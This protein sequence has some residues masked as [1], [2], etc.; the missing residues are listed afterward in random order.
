M[1]G[2]TP[3]PWYGNQ[4]YVLKLAKDGNEFKSFLKSKKDKIRGEDYLFY[5]GVT[6]SLISSKGFA[7]RLSPGGFIFDVAGMTC[8][9]PEDSISLVL[10]VLNSRIAKFILLALNPTINFQV[11]DIERLPVPEERSPIIDSLVEECVELTRQGSRE[12]EITYEFIAPPES[13]GEVDDRTRLLSEKETLI[14][15]EVSKL[16]GLTDEDLFAIEREL[17]GNEISSGEEDIEEKEQ[18]EQEE[19]QAG[20][21]FS[22]E[23]WGRRW[24]S[25][26]VGIA[27]GRF[28]AGHEGGLGSG[29]FDSSVAESLT[30]MASPE[31]I[32]VNDEG[33]PNDLAERV[34]HILTTALGNSEAVSRTRMALGEGDSL[35]LLRNWFER[36]SGT[37]ENSFWKYHLKVYRKRP[38]YWPLQS[39]GRKFTLW[40]FHERLTKD[41]LYS[42][43]NSIVE[44]RMRLAERR[45]ADLRPRAE[46][47]RSA[48]MEMERARDL[49]EDLRTFSAN[50]LA[51]TERG[52]TP[53]IDDGVLLN[54]APLWTLLPSWTDTRKSWKELE[55]GAFDWSHQAMEHW[56][57]RVKNACRNNRSF[58]IAHGME[59]LAPAEG[60][61]AATKKRARKNR[62]A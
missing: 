38:V 62:G 30:E 32:L 54:A 42:I 53:H 29:K 55:E 13:L 5:R 33:Q 8:F 60:T 26:A 49:A 6:W 31:G 51:V 24:I 50:L 40:L 59:H 11:G 39:P 25:Y 17:S 9:P 58:A 2:G 7:A 12:S 52:Y 3:I 27:L 15:A 56:P 22:P 20:G 45:I 23:E 21:Q 28:E 44:P 61:L 43:K 16:Y 41:T 35:S 47:E 57:E 18:D 10:G 46:N 37:P 48:R 14:D 36:F 1:K 19:V 34:F 4:E